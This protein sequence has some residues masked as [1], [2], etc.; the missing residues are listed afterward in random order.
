MGRAGRVV[1]KSR[2]GLAG[3]CGVGGAV[4]ERGVPSLLEAAAKMIASRAGG[5]AVVRPRVVVLCSCGGICVSRPRAEVRRGYRGLVSRL[6]RT[7]RVGLRRGRGRGRGGGPVAGGGYG[8]GVGRAGSRWWRSGHAPPGLNLLLGSHRS[9]VCLRSGKSSVL[10]TPFKADTGDARL[11]HNISR[12]RPNYIRVAIAQVGVAVDDAQVA[13]DLGAKGGGGLCAGAR[14]GPA[15][16][17]AAVELCVKVREVCIRCTYV[18]VSGGR[19]RARPRVLA[20]AVVRHV[21]PCSQPPARGVK[22]G[23]PRDDWPRLPRVV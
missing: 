14:L 17:P 8:G 11:A 18:R 1:V 10:S 3:K 15:R 20:C 5:V 6:P 13:F 12:V 9:D 16:A 7:V 19:A 22:G 4:L 2:C 23:S 21:I